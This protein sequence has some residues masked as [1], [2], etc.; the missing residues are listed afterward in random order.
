M[1]SLTFPER[2]RAALED[3][4]APQCGPGQILVRA[5]YTGMTNGTERNQLLGGN[6]NP[7]T[8]PV[9]IL[10]Y[11]HVGEVI[12]VGAGV[13][14][15]AVGDVVYSDTPHRELN[16]AETGAGANTI[17][18]PESVEPKHAALFGVAGV[19][20]H[21]VARAD[22]LQGERCLV[23]GAGLIGQMTARIAAAKGAEVWI[24]DVD[25]ERLEIAAEE[26][27]GPIAL[28]EE[29]RSWSAVRERGPFD[30][31]FEDSGA[32]VLDRIFG[33]GWP[34]EVY[35]DGP[36]EPG[37]THRSPEIDRSR[38]GKRRSRVVVV[39]G[40]DRVSYDFNAAQVHEISVLHVSHFDS[41]D[42]GEVVRMT[43]A[44]EL[45]IGP[46]IKDEMPIDEAPRAYARLASD[47]GSLLGT[48][49]AWDG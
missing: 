29:A 10:G 12:E 28:T 24:C 48:I 40:R 14:G 9:P 16:L 19:A 23:V 8:W 35:P 21:S 15:F 2:G 3:T 38:V 41:A 36:A 1:I 43:A 7:G 6:Y 49:F 17:L 39:A 22:L 25:P 30:V 27:V 18:V 26:G 5:V 44:G 20:M 11:Q 47:P 46:L 45:P 31:V 33:R 4:S 34:G 42:L 13:D 37:L 32:P